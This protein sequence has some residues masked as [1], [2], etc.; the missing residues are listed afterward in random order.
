M[1]AF[2]MIRRCCFGHGLAES[3]GPSAVIVKVWRWPYDVSSKD[4]IGDYPED[5]YYAHHPGS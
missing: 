3:W 2:L 4:K 5:N 1:E